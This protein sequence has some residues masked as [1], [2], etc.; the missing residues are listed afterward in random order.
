MRRSRRLWCLASI[1]C[2]KSASC[3]CPTFVHRVTVDCGRVVVENVPTGVEDFQMEL[4]EARK[5]M[6]KSLGNRNLRRHCLAVS[7]VMGALA[8]R[9]GGDEQTW[10]LAGMLHDL[11]YEQT[12]DEPR[13]HGLLTAD[14]LRERG[15][16]AAVVDAVLAHN[17]HKEAETAMEKAI[18]C[19]DAVT[20]LVVA[21]ALIRP[22]KKLSALTPE[23]V[24]KKMRE[25][26][27]ARGADRDKIAYHDRLDL[28]KEE[29]L[30]ISV[31]A[32]KAIS[33][34]LGL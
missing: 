15:V 26:S 4:E 19:A 31:D 9:L 1:S 2:R 16:D 12:K 27:F 7:A 18:V 21:A 32:M 20:G 6:E 10:R 17:H 11:D 5:L 3:G 14:E 24:A 33:D 8:R 13:R 30:Q 25:P 22:E 34:D 29:F 28:S 23:F